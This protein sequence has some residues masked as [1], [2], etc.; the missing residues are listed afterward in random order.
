ML[1]LRGELEQA[2]EGGQGAGPRRLGWVCCGK[3]GRGPDAW[4]LPGLTVWA[5]KKVC[6]LGCWAEGHGP[7]WAGASAGHAGETGW[8]DGAR[9]GPA[10]RWERALGW[11]WAALGRL[12]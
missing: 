9:V 5:R 10:G 1:G 11:P 3:M 2:R 4:R 12:G 6:G 8:A 7:S